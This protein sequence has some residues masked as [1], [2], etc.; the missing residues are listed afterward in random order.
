MGWFLTQDFRRCLDG[1]NDLVVTRAAT[2]VVREEKTNLMF[3]RIREFFQ[4]RLGGHQKARC[5]NSA[6]KRR[7][8]EETLLQRMKVAFVS[9]SF[10]G[11][12][13]G[14]GGFWGKHNTTVDRHAVHQHRASATISIVAPFLGPR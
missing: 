10:H 1:A 4:E 6:L 2:K 14:V 7:P 3:R 12:N 8:F 5:A 13:V 9:D 11:F